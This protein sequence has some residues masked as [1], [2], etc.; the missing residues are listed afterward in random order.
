MQTF[1]LIKHYFRILGITSSQS[2]W[3]DLFKIKNAV[4]F[5]VM[6]M[7]LSLTVAFAYYE[8]NSYEE[9]ADSF[10]ATTSA[11]ICLY[12]YGLLFLE[13]PELYRFFDTLEKTITESNIRICDYNHGFV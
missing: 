7:Y 8:T 10:Y 5:L 12:S 3:K 6:V 11:F 13:L 4:F 2:T 1:D 9:Y